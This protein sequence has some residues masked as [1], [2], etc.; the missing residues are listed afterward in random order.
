VWL[1]VVTLVALA[2]SRHRVRND[3][4]LGRP[5]PAEEY[6]RKTRSHARNEW[7]FLKI[8]A[9]MQGWFYFYSLHRLP[10]LQRYMAA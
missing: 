1:K 7:R 9:R 8:P 4:W 3:C 2:R 5:V 10:I 6:L